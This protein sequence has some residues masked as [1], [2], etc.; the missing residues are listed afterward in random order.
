MVDCGPITGQNATYTCWAI[1]SATF[2]L[3]LVP[4]TSQLRERRALDDNGWRS[5]AP[6]PV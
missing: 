5:V 3:S 6:L 4:L 1:L 2:R